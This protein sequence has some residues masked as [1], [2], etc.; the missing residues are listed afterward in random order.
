VPTEFDYGDASATLSGMR[1]AEPPYKPICQTSG[2]ANCILATVRQVRCLKPFK[3]L[4]VPPT[5]QATC[6]CVRCLKPCKP[7]ASNP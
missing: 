1:G 2:G 7:L 4:G 6:L 5:M 3:G